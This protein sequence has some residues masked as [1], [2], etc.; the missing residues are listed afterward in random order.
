M[1]LPVLKRGSTGAAVK[2]WQ[3]FLIGQGFRE[4]VA[5]GDFGPKT[6]AAT[7][8]YQAAKGLRDDGVVGRRTYAKAIED[9]FDVIVIDPDFP[10]KP[11]FSPLVSMAERQ[12]LFGKFEF[13]PAPTN[14]NPERIKILGD[15]EQNNIISVEVAA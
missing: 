3:H 6:E 4:V 14:D 5:D 12:E 10:F 1:V 13:E 7:Q 9:G 11:D 2:H 8:K 15:W